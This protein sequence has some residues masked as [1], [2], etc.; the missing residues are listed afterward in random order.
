MKLRQ[1]VLSSG[2]AFA[3]AAMAYTPAFAVDATAAA[4]GT[5][6]TTGKQ[7]T[8]T[9]KSIRAANHAFSRTVQKAIFRTKGLEAASIAVFGDAKTGHVTLAGQIDSEE[10]DGLAVDAAQKVQGVTSVSSKLM[11]REQGGG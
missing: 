11:V 8:T 7:A 10:Q 4:S 6:I 9:K 2:L 3:V 1:L 5:I